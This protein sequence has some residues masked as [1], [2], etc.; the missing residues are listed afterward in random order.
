MGFRDLRAVAAQAV[1]RAMADSALLLRG[2]EDPVAVTVRVFSKPMDVGE[3]LGG[4]LSARAYATLSD[5]AL[6]AVFLDPATVPQKGDI[7][8]CVPGEAYKLVVRVKPDGPTIV[9]EVT[10]LNA[11]EAAGLPVPA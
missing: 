3:L 8:S 5:A 4:G 9:W 6:H 2:A 7:L 10:Q 1:H 11:A